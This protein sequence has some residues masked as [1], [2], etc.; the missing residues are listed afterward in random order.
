[1][2]DEATA[3]RIIEG[4]KGRYPDAQIAHTGG[5]FINV[6]WTE[7]VGG[8]LRSYVLGDEGGNFAVDTYK[9]DYMQDDEALFLWPY[10]FDDLA[11]DQVIAELIGG[12]SP[13]D[14][15]EPP[16]TLEP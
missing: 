4:M 12:G 3:E 1:M 13:R 15:S 6:Y 9:G 11:E 16:A 8:E 10:E 2:M 7:V 14:A 5:G